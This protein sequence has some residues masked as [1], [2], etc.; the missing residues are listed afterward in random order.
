M[1]LDDLHIDPIEPF[2]GMDEVASSISLLSVD[3]PTYEEA[4]QLAADCLSSDSTTLTS[5]DG[6][7]PSLSQSPPKEPLD[8]FSNVSPYPS[9]GHPAAHMS[10]VGLPTPDPSPIGNR[11]SSTASVN[12]SWGGMNQMKVSSQPQM[13]CQ[14]QQTLPPY[15]NTV[16]SPQPPMQSKSAYLSATIKK[17]EKIDIYG[18][19]CVTGQSPNPM[20][21][22]RGMQQNVPGNWPQQQPQ[23]QQQAA[24]QR[25]VPPQ[26]YGWKPPQ[27]MHNHMQNFGGERVTTASMGTENPV[28]ATNMQGRRW[29][30]VT[31]PPLFEDTLPSLQYEGGTGYMKAGQN[32]GGHLQHHSMDPSILSPPYQEDYHSGFGFQG[33]PLP[34]NQEQ[35]TLGHW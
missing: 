5:P 28:Y 20:T 2:A 16:P 23:Q 4:I 22:P 35:T 24:P 25:N 9:P 7:H 3:P 32:I 10:P 34:M 1:T 33:N 13:Q 21:S 19:S 8:H 27:Q 26:G 11:N 6:S 29:D 18:Q 14:P 31:V 17:I 12:I 15:N 30:T